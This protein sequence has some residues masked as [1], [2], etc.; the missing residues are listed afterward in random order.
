MNGVCEVLQR[1]TS[2]AYRSRRPSGVESP[3]TGPRPKL[4]MPT[5]DGSAMQSARS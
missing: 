2:P 1:K 4:T 5:A 3:Q